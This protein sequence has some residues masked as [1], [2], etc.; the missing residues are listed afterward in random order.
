MA[1]NSDEMVQHVPDDFHT[2]LA[3]VTGPDARVRTA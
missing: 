2:L 3:D 1:S